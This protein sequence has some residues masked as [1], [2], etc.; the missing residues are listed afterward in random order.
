MADLQTKKRGRPIKT[1]PRL[2]E[3]KIIG[4]AKLLMRET[5]KIPSIRKLSSS[6]NVDAM[7]IY[8]YFDNKNKLLEGLITSL[9]SEVYLPCNDDDWQQE[10]IALASSYLQLLHDYD[11]LLVTLLSMGSDSPAY[12][13]TQRFNQIIEPLQLSQRQ[14]KLMLDLVV[15]YLHGFSLALSCDKSRTLKIENIEQPMLFMCQH[16]A[17]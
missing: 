15:D 6:L 5:G 13:F 8:Y 14:Q 1:K 17:N 7:A 12:V 4:A 16:I 3:E 10:L 2:S 9:I 11:G